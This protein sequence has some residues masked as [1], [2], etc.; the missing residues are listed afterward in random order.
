MPKA[1]AMI[2]LVG[3]QITSNCGIQLG[4]AWNEYEMRLTNIFCF[5]AYFD[6]F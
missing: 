5:D 1:A 2:S 3:T 4:M 6:I